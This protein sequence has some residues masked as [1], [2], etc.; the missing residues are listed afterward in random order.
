MI[1]KILEHCY[2]GKIKYTNSADEENVFM[3]LGKVFYNTNNHYDSKLDCEIV[4]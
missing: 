2:S 3:C 1:E 4:F